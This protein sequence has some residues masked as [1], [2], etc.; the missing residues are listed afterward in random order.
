MKK[1]LYTALIT[2]LLS[3]FQFPVYSQDKGV[4]TGK[5]T[6]VSTGDIG[7]AEK[8]TL[9]ILSMGMK[10]I[11]TIEN[12]EGNFRFD[13]IDVDSL[14][15]YLLQTYYKNVVYNLTFRFNENK[16]VEA[17]IKIYDKTDLEE[18]ISVLLP[19][20]LIKLVN[21]DL[22][23]SKLFE[24]NNDKKPEKVFYKED[25]TFRFFIPEDVK[26]VIRVTTSMGTLSTNQKY[27]K[28]NDKGIY[29][30][31]YPMKPGKTRIEISYSVDYSKKAYIFSEDIVYNVD[32]LAVL[33]SPGNIEIKG[34]KLETSNEGAGEHYKIYNTENL[35]K[36]TKLTFEIS[37]GK[38]EISN[39]TAGGSDKIQNPEI[40]S[41]HVFSNKITIIAVTFL[42]ILIIIGIFIKNFM[43]KK[44]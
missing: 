30:I 33:V 42:I 32:K 38:S 2:I 41:I 23:I 16:T 39:M 13:N 43:R 27:K 6:N 44:N 12:V 9:F 14:F 28:E 21:N 37:G 34:D 7:K 35:K 18:Q 29:S 24:I 31:L 19:H 15:P 26:E 25:G 5:I 36:G 1:I 22:I 40:K 10:E 8:I 20:M 3:Y 4:I 17:D 11:K